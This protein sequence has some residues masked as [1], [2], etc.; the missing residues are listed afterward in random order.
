MKLLFYI[1]LS[2]CFAAQ[3]NIAAQSKNEVLLK[4]DAQ[5]KLTWADYK[6][7]PN[8]FSDAAAS[9]STYLVISYDFYQDKMSYKIKSYFSATRSWGRHKT[10]YILS[11]EQGHFDIA[12]IF[13]RKLYKEMSEYK[14]EGRKSKQGLDDIYDKII[15]EKSAMQDQYDK[16]TN[17]SINEKKQAEWIAKIK[18]LLEQYAAYSDY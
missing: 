11:H 15:R 10:P 7:Q 17:H 8:Q 6:G 16:E 9:T 4:W 2:F 13:A 14:Y 1:L 12:E 3:N 18:L 5:K